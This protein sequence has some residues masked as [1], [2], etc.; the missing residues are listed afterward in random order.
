MT[1]KDGNNPDSEYNEEVDIQSVLLIMQLLLD[2][3]YILSII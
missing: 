1:E 3:F 2:I